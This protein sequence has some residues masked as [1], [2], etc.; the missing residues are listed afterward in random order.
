MLLMG[1]QKTVRTL[2]LLKETLEASLAAGRAGRVRIATGQVA[3]AAGYVTGAAAATGACARPLL[4]ACDN[5]GGALGL[6][7][8]GQRS[9]RRGA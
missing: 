4:A 6:Q 8:L 2:R 9:R 7:L 5:R 3:R 1:R